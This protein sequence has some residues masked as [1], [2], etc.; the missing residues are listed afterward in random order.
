MIGQ[1]IG[2]KDRSDGNGEVGDDDQGDDALRHFLGKPAFPVRTE[3]VLFD[4][5][6]VA[7]YDPAFRHAMIGVDVEFDAAIARLGR[8]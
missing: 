1:G 4:R 2:V 5:T 3:H 8:I 6:Y 7:I